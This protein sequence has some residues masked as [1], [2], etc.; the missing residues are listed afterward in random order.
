MD[1]STWNWPGTVLAIMP[2]H[3]TGLYVHGQLNINICLVTI[4]VGRF[5]VLSHSCEHEVRWKRTYL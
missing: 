3:G 5:G 4:L 2:A 1:V